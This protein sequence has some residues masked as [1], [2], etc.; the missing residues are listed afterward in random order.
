MVS[1]VA[2][3]LVALLP[4][5]IEFSTLLASELIFDF[6]IIAMLA[7]LTLVRVRENMARQGSKRA[8]EAI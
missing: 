4:V 1:I 5:Q 3:A 6:I 2:G 8:G 7:A